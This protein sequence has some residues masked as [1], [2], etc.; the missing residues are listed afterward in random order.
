LGVESSQEEAESRI[1]KVEAL[2]D[3]LTDDTKDSVQHLQ[4]LVTELTSKVAMLT[5]ALNLGK[6]HQ[7]CNPTQLGGTDPHCYGGARDAKEL[8]NFLFDMEQYFRAT[9]PDSEDTKVSIATMYLNGDAKLWWRTR[10]EEIQQGRCRVDTWDDLKRELRTQFLPENTEFVAR[11]KLR[12]LHQTTSIRDYVKQFS[13]LMLDIQDMSE[14]D[15]LFSFLDGLKPWAQQELHRRNVT[16]LVG[17]IA[18]AERL[19]DF[20]SSEDPRKKKQSTGNHQPRH[21]PGKEPRGEQR[22]KSFHKGSNSNGRASKPRTCFLCGGPH[23]VWDCPQKQA[24]NALSAAIKTP[25]PDKGKAVALSSSSSESGS[26]DEKSQGPRMGAMRLLNALRGQVGENLK[27]KQQKAGSSELMY[28]NIRLNGQ[29]TRAMV[30]TGATHNFIADR[31]AKRLGL[32]L[33]K[34]PSRMKAVNSEA[35][36]ISG[37][38]KGVSIKIGSWSG[39]TNM[40]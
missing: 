36:R 23:S 15:K 34:N 28:V 20:A 3:R 1:D 32:I 17:A 4:D 24:L 2:V 39:R 14:K 29:T 38:A 40:M 33:E 9:R 27:P 6:Q 19:T 8:E 22:K 25:K 30:D 5:R 31:E 16:D 37:L 7:R 10:W 13:A 35:K 26:D 21:P 11:R 12:Q 18:A